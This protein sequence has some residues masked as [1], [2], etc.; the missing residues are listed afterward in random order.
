M[1][2]EVIAYHTH[3]GREP[4]TEWLRSLKDIGLRQRIETRVNRIRLGNLGDHKHFQG[5]IELRLHFGKGYRIYCGEENDLLVILLAVLNINGLAL[6]PPNCPFSY[7][8]NIF[9]LAHRA[10][11]FCTLLSVAPVATIFSWN[12]SHTRGTPKK[13][14]GRTA[15]N[16]SPKLPFSTSGRAK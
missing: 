9:A 11:F 7:A 16:V 13:Y 4:F 10:T 1:E 12:F 5:I 2:K 3:N 6:L 15:R 8:V 14:V